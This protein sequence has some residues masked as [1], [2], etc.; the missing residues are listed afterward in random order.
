MAFAVVETG[1]KQYKIAEGD[2]FK[3]EKLSGFKTGDSV[4]FDKVLVLDNGTSTKVGTPYLKDTTITVELI[5][6]GK[7]KKLF[8]QK[9]KAKSRYKRRLGHRQEFAKVKVKNLE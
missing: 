7:G 6:E 5:E 4:T 8:I 9:Y 3:V 2:V 1:G